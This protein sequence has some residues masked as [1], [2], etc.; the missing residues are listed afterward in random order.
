MKHY[1]KRMLRFGGKKFYLIP[2]K[3]LLEKAKDFIIGFDTNKQKTEVYISQTKQTVDITNIIIQ[4]SF[5]YTFTFNGNY[6]K[7]KNFLHEFGFYI[8]STPE[9]AELVLI[10]DKGKAII[11]RQAPAITICESNDLFSNSGN[12]F[13]MIDMNQN[14]LEIELENI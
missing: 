5:F 9:I 1:R 3:S 2:R 11:I 13:N 12:T 7:F 8:Q 4:L 6:T 10:S 14:K